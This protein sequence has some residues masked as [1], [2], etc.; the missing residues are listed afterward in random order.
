MA[1]QTGFNLQPY[2]H[3]YVDT[4]V[5]VVNAAASQ[6]IG[7]RRAVVD[8][9]GSIRLARYVPVTSEK[10][11]VTTPQNDV[12][13]YA[14]MADKE[15]HIVYEVGGAVHPSHWGQGIGTRLLEW[16]EQ[17]ARLLS[18]SAPVGVKTVLQTN[19]YETEPEAIQLFT[20]N[21]YTKVR[22]WLHLVVELNAPP[23]LPVCPDGLYLR[24]MD[25]ENDW[26]IVGP[27]LDEAFADHWGTI[28]LPASEALLSEE[29]EAPVNDVPQDETYSN[30]PGFCYVLM[31]GDVVAGG[32]LCN[33][34]LVERSDTGRIGSVFVCA[35]YRRQGAGRALMLTA[36]HAFWQ[37]GI[38]RII[39]DTDADSFTEA[40]KFYT[41]LGMRWYRREFLYEKEMR[42]GK[43]VR[44]LRV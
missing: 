23:L 34:K 4:A 31:D 29:E 33:A 32:V 39:T 24:E 9:V 42:P 17:R 16:A 43:E 21:G 38:R 18:D 1:Q 12:V 10:I 15:Q 11:I 20:R 26:G 27:A 40:P 13:G 44:R 6:T 36:F 19:L 25:L 2:T 37:H 35:P 41:H 8:S 14:Y 3:L 22:E 5:Q 28:L 30:T 7:V